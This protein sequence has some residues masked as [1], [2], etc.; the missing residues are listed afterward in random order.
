M[1]RAFF[2]IKWG[3]VGAVGLLSGAAALLITGAWLSVEFILDPRSVV[4]LN[5][6]LPEGSKILVAGSDDLRTLAELQAAL[7]KTGRAIGDP[8]LLD[9]NFKDIQK[10]FRSS[11]ARAD[12]PRSL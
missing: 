11:F 1:S 2:Q 12:S 3:T 5:P 4:W 7:K 9:S 8:I 6:Y 10:I